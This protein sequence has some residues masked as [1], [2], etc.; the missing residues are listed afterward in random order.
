MAIYIFKNIFSDTEKYC[1]PVVDHACEDRTICLLVNVSSWPGLRGDIVLRV[2]DLTGLL[3]ASA[4]S[5]RRRL[6]L[7][8][9]PPALTLPVAGVLKDEPL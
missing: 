9:P 4:P 5:S 3:T 6:L 1:E 2:R 7:L 8:P